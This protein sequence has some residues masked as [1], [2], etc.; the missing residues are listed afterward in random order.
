MSQGGADSP[1]AVRTAQEQFNRQAAHYDRQW[2]AWNEE[3]LRWLL[4]R[5]RPG[6]RGRVL[7]VATGC[8]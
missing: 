2:N 1:V 8:H 4:D 7:D 3:S 5:G 6:P